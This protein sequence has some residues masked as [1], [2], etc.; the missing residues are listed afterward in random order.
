M[1]V[2]FLKILKILHQHDVEF[3]VVGA[4][5]AALQGAQIST[6]DLDIVHNR[7]KENTCRLEAALR[8]LGAVYRGHPAR[9]IPTQKHLESPGHQLLSTDFGP[10]DALGAIENSLDYSA[11]LPLSVV[12]EVGA[13]VDIHIMTLRSYYD[14]RKEHPRPRDLT[15]FSLMEAALSIAE[16]S[17]E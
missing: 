12:R 10:L 8:E 7:S 13:G 17:D 5:S 3:V 15:R 14:L 6:F 2:D 4:T 9:I 1:M 11:L 16:S